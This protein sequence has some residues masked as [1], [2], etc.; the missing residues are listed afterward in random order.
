MTAG[1]DDA[2]RF[3][4]AYE[5]HARAILAYA[6]R[7]CGSLDAAGD[8]LADTML[9]A[10]RRIGDL[11][12]EPDT[13]LWL[14]GVARNV[15]ANHHRSQLRRARLGDRLRQQ[16][17]DSANDISVADPAISTSVRNALAQL[18][19]VEREVMLLTAAEGLTPNQISTVL[20]MN[21][22]TV[23]THLQRAR[24]KLRNDLV[25]RGIIV[26][27]N[28]AVGRKHPTGHERDGAHGALYPQ[29]TQ[30]APR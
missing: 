8:I 13:R 6:A 24:R 3:R 12:S 18:S 26:D 5:T 2:G 23:R 25:A 1:P 11:P 4:I 27:I 9:V 19:S 20:D 21:A 28:D 29:R 15:L 10:W 30:E 14:Y 7:R 17:A 22:S 16:L